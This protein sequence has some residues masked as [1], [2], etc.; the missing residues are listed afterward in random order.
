MYP[1]ITSSVS[2]PKAASMTMGSQ[3]ASRPSSWTSHFPC[4]SRRLS[5]VMVATAGSA[6]LASTVTSVRKG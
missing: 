5:K 1:R 2:L 4:S 6:R 3:G